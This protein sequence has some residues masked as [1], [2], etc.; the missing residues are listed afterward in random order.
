MVLLRY[1]FFSSPDNHL[2]NSPSVSSCV[3]IHHHCLAQNGFNFPLGHIG[4]DC[5]EVPAY[6]KVEQ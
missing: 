1:D 5:Y 4:Y 6:V 2:H 3:P